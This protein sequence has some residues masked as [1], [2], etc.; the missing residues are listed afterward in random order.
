[1]R[2]I[3]TLFL[4][5]F[6]FG[7]VKAQDTITF[8]VD[9]NNYLGSYTGIYLNGDFNNWCGTC[10]PMSDSD[11]DK[12]WTVSVP[13]T[14]DSIEYKFTLDGWTGQEQFAGGESC[15][16]TNGGFTN[17][18]L[19]I[20]GNATLDTVCF[21]LCTTCPPPKK[22]IALPISWDATDVDYS[23]GDFEG[24]SSEIVADPKNASNNVLKSIKKIDGKPWAGTTLSTGAGLAKAAPFSKDSNL[25]SV[26][27]LSPDTGIMVR[28]KFEDAND[29]THTVE[30]EA[31]VT[32]AN[33]WETLVFDFSKQ[34]ANTAAINYTYTFN[35]VSIFYNFGV[36]GATAGEKTYYCDNVRFGGPAKA[37]GPKVT[38]KVDMSQYSGTYSEVNLNGNFNSWCGNCAKMTDADNDDIYEIEVEFDKLG[39]IE[40]KFTVDGWTAQE[41]FAGGES[42]TKTTG[43][44]TNR[45]YNVQGDATLDVVCWESCS[46]CG[47]APAKADVTFKVDMSKSTE[48]FTEVN[49]NGNFNG[50][51]GSCAKMTDDD[52]DDIYELTVTVNAGDS[53]EYKFTL[54]GWTAQ[55]EFKGGEDCTI[56]KGAFTNRLLVPAGDSILA[57][58]CYNSCESCGTIG[59]ESMDDNSLTLYPNPNNG[60]FTIELQESVAHDIEIVNTNGQVVFGQYSS[61]SQIQHLD[62]GHLTKGVY[63][64]KVTTSANA[65]MQ[66]L[67]VE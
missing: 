47:T 20:N 13:L 64:V 16:K 46:A 44:F 33:E 31:K 52:N 5:L 54:D 53:L 6:A 28:L 59:I 24:N 7:M 60:V 9:M 45:V 37:A 56:T 49:L 32:K 43:G 23:V 36:D 41:N 22:Q 15:T 27:V 1:M 26:D 35:K 3:S 30:T 55:E 29:N 39:D 34:A 62:L 18:F 51:C 21:N 40:Y 38:F 2:K 67:V 19:L 11:N 42:C 57:A 63:L 10:T 17:R 65:I 58:V 61:N 14:A 50:W 4:A 48:T 25:V 8:A 12:V 66:K